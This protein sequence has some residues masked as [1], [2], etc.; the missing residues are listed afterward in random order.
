LIFGSR[1]FSS[2]RLAGTSKIT[3]DEFDALFQ[4]VETALQVFDVLNRRHDCILHD[5]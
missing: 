4:F 5:I 3:P 1:D 2:S